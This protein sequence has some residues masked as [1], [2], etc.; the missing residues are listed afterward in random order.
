MPKQEFPPVL[1]FTVSL[2]N[3]ILRCFLLMLTNITQNN[4]SL[5]SDSCIV[6]F[7]LISLFKVLY[8]QHRRPKNLVFQ[9]DQ[10]E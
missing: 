9:S 3:T 6:K 8:R 2:F 1:L 4:C 7:L 5:I 10:L